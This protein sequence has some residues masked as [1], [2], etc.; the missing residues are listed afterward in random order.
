M[1]RA[2]LVSIAVL[3]L[4]G[5]TSRLVTN[6]PRSALEQ[7]LLTGAVDKALAKFEARAVNGKKVF[8]DFSNL[9]AYD[10][11][12]IKTAARARFSQLGA[13]LVEKA[14][15]AEMIAE[16]ACGASGTEFKSSMVGLPAL[17]VPNSPI[18]LPESAVYKRTEQTGILKLLIFL[19]SKGT[20]VAAY[21][22]YAKADR[23][24]GFI[25]WSRFQQIDDVREGWERADLHLKEA[26]KRPG[27]AR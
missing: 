15:D 13:T 22:C 3:C 16:V 21:Y 8:L 12:Y 17:P 10:A 24:E 5:C 9:Q 2:T 26:T 19:H 27:P 14:E 4:G 6:T 23:T 11:G 18:P 25:F 7:L 1:M 20:F